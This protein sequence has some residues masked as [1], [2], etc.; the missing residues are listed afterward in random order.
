VR[1]DEIRQDLHAGVALVWTG[2]P[3]VACYCQDFLKAD[4]QHVYRQIVSLQRWQPRV[5]T[6]KRGEAERFPF[7]AKHLAVLPPLRWRH[8]RRWWFRAVRREP[9]VIPAVRVRELLEAVFR[10]EAGVVHVFFGHIAVMLLPFLRVCPRPVV[11]SFHGADA[12]VD[13]RQAAHAAL[14]REVFARASLVLARS[15]ALLEDLAAAGCPREKLRLQRTGI[16][17][18]DWPFVER[19]PPE[20]GSWRFLQACRLVPK[21]GLFCTLRA[22]AEVRRSLPEA[23][24]TLA[25]DGPLAGELQREA[26]RLGLSGRV[27]FPGF[28]DAAGLRAAMGRA[29]VFL[30]PSETPADG[31]R[32][33][34]PNAMLEAMATGLP[35]LA[36]RHGGIP[37]A[38]DDGR[39][40]FLV[41]E[42]D[43]G[44]LAAAAVRLCADPGIYASMAVAARESMQ[45]RF[46]R[47]AQTAVLESL[48]D[49]ARER[50]VPP[51][52]TFSCGGNSAVT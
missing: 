35:V 7:A 46:A 23:R 13:L 17:L 20:D 24:L 33:G 30:H 32:E 18:G 21:K 39:N 25:G 9:L 49:E 12:G 6:Q 2:M 5:I 43:A 11:V 44:G 48:Y 41:A 1:T 14:L 29:H 15:E 38:V 19:R 27:D 50:G 36:T 42:G 34:V 28:L 10:A 47:E 37:E 51:R 8:A 26:Q 16:P 45:E 31:N 52:K 22:F 4:M 3:V 40:G